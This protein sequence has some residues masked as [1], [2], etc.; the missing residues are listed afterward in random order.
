ERLILELCWASPQ[1][2]R[3]SQE[4]AL[5]LLRR[6]KIF[7]RICAC[8]NIYGIGAW[9]DTKKNKSIHRMDRDEMKPLVYDLTLEG[10]EAWAAERSLPRFRAAQIFDWLYVKRVTDFAAMT[11]L[12][13]QL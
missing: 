12:P 6:Q 7:K 2:D 9:V 10:W 11:N 13:K 8:D 4:R 5:S 1:R 3:I